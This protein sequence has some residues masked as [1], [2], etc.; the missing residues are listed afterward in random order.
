M[1]E[2]F[3]SEGEELM[4]V[5]IAMTEYQRVNTLDNIDKLNTGER[6]VVSVLFGRIWTMPLNYN[7]LEVSFPFNFQSFLSLP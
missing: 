2:E 4:H 3:L 1:T 6:A 7:L 5:C